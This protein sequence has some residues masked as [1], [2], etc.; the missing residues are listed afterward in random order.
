MKSYH[1]TK[2]TK[3]CPP[4]LSKSIDQFRLFYRMTKNSVYAMVTIFFSY[5]A[6]VYLWLQSTK[7]YAILPG[8]E[9]AVGA[10]GSG[11]VNIF[12]SVKFVL[13]I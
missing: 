12:Q 1:H 5:F 9:K 8:I 7:Y 13:D 6:F 4:R 10:A 3:C 11:H 2:I